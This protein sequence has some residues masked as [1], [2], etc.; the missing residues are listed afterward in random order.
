MIVATILELKPS[1]FYHEIYKSGMLNMEIKDEVQTVDMLFTGRSRQ[2][3]VPIYQRRYVWEEKN[4]DMLWNDI[5]KMSNQ[6]FTGIIVTRRHDDT[7]DLEKY[8]VIDGQQ[9]ITTFQIMLCVIRDVCLSKSYIG[10][11]EEA[12][13]L[14]KNEGRDVGDEE[15]YKLLLKEESDDESAFRALVEAEP[16]GQHIIHRAYDHFEELI[17]DY[18]LSQIEKIYTDIILRVNVAQIDLVQGDMS[19]KIFA[20]LNATGRMLDEFDYLRNDLFLRAGGD[21]EKFYKSEI[22]WHPSF[23]DDDAK[24]LDTFL[25][26]FLKANLGP[27]CFHSGLKSFELYQQ[28]YR[29]Q[30]KLSID[31]EFTRL[32]AFARFNKDMN[33]P[34]SEIGKH[35]QFYNDLGISPLDSFILLIKHKA[36]RDDIELPKIYQILES[37]IIRHLLCEGQCKYE[38]INEFFSKA[39]ED[40][41]EF[42]VH[43][44]AK[45]LSKTWPDYEQV[46]DALKQVPIHRNSNLILYILYR[47]ELRIRESLSLPG[48]SFKDLNTIVRLVLPED[49]ISDLPY[50][51]QLTERVSEVYEATDSIGNIAATTTSNIPTDWSDLSFVKKKELLETQVAPELIL[52]QNISELTDCGVTEIQ[53]RINKELLPV[54]NEIWPPASEF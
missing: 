24:D 25:D 16:R 31:E 48:L 34:S 12:D 36:A 51:S 11:A 44:F 49:L 3:K 4:W 39:I 54:F 29:N 32:S 14:I 47:I 20:S 22:H 40:S 52:T 41:F 28:D 7:G 35:M 19:E 30:L 27:T 53:E 5:T 38:S 2:Y 43:E 17:K 21:S 50:D 45:F 46:L 1:N 42:S 18:D 33:N 23:E 8:D 10:K 6:H 15:R 13:R 9:R 37:Y 26:D